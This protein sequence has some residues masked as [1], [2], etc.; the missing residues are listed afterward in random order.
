MVDGNESGGDNDTLNLNVA[1]QGKALTNIIYDP[2]NP[3]NGTVQ[4]LDGSGAVIGSMTFTNIENV[5]PCFTPGTVIQTDRGDVAVEALV[6]GDFVL[7]RD[8]GYQPLCWVGRRDLTAADLAVQPNLNPVL[9][10]A[11]ALGINTPTRDMLVSPQ[12]RMLFATP[13]AEMM[14]GEPEVLI[15]ATHLVGQHGILRAKPKGVSYIHIMCERHEI[16][17]AN[18][19]W[20]ESY[21]P[22]ALTL[23]SLHQDQRDELI[24]LFPF[25]EFG[26]PDYPASRLSLKAH[27]ARV[28]LA[29]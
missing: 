5:I 23:R 8:N 28:L 13:R 1:G 10:A 6:A 24:A 21:Q 9:I 7:T 18:G 15:A 12:H 29:A 27:E 19:C 17:R 25:L 3:E 20:T 16:I 26:N 14:F 11:G 2:G 4:F 22:G